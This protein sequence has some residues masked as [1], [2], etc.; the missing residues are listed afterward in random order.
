MFKCVNRIIFDLDNTLIR[1]DFE[2]ESEMIAKELGFEGSI[3]FKIQLYNFFSQ[4]MGD[5]KWVTITEENYAKFIENH[6]PLLKETGKS[7][8]DF[9]IAMQKVQPGSLMVGAKEL[10]EYLYNKGYEIVALTNWFY[11]HQVSVL[12]KFDILNYFEK[13]YSWDNY[14]PK[15]NRLAM[16]RAINYGEPYKNVVIGDDPVGDISV[17][18]KCGIKTIGFN[19]DYSKYENCDKLQKADVVVKKL[20]DIQNYL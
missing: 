12:K 20:E 10:L 5:F 16:M 1:H 9:L 17:A 14:F 3:A 11:T 6:I 15:P 7:G 18:K 2:K 8:K 13:I 4:G 19:I